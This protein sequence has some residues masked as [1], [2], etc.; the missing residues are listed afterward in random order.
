MMVVAVRMIDGF[1]ESVGG[2][3]DVGIARREGGL[4]DASAADDLLLP[5][6]PFQKLEGGKLAVTGQFLR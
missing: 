2:G 1:I 4:D 3:D 5:A 6:R